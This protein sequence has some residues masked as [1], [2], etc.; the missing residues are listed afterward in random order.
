MNL[1]LPHEQRF[2]GGYR[3]TIKAV[4]S[5]TLHRLAQGSCYGMWDVATRTIYIDK[6]ATERKQR[7]ALT[8]ELQHALA[9]WIHVYLG[10]DRD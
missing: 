1:H 10:E 7:Y 2:P 8:H 4:A 3:V 9:D 6:N 5:R